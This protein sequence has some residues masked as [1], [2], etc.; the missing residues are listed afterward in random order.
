MYKY[1]FTTLTTP[2]SDDAYRKLLIWR[3]VAAMLAA[4]LGFLAGSLPM[5]KRHGDFSTG[6]LI[7]LA[8]GVV[9]MAIATF[10]RIW[11]LRHKSDDQIRQQMIKE[12][13]ERRQ[14]NNLKALKI[15]YFLLL[16]SLY[17]PFFYFANHERIF[18]SFM[19]M[20]IMLGSFG[21]YILIWAHFNR[22][23]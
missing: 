9:V 14:Y 6:F 15:S 7:G 10:V 5:P 20:V 23:Q 19:M 21:S 13:D 17:V 8:G 2:M 16:F 11:Q 3:A 12:T 18:E 22:Y 1:I 4:I